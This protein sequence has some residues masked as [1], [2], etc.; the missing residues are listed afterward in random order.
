[1]TRRTATG[2]GR[3]RVPTRI[4]GVARM[5]A[6]DDPRDV[7]VTYALGSCLGICL[8]DAEARVGGMLHTMLP[9]SRMNLERAK[10]NPERFVDTGVPALF[11]ACYELGARKERIVVKV[12]GGANP[13]G[14]RRPDGF[15]IG[16]RNYEALTEVLRMNGVTID[17]EDVGGRLSRTLTLEIGS[18]RVTVRNGSQEWDL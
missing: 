13:S 10:E 1:M 8:H 6:S 15:R 11:H 9:D 3:G 5:G 17:S 7:L 2:G 14:V 12:A 18:G 16:R 4:V